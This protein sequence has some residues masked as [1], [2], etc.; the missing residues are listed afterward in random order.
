MSES[1]SKL[2]RNLYRAEQVR[3]LDRLAIEEFNIAGIELM[4]KAGSVAFD[5]V[6]ENWPQTR[7]LQIFTGSGNNAGDGFIVAGLA[8][9][10]GLSVDV[11][12][13]GDVDKLNGEAK[14][15]YDWACG[16]KVSMR[17]YS[18]ID[19]ERENEHAQTAIIDALLGTGLDRN[20]EGEY[21]SAIDYLNSLSAPVVAIDMPSGLS[22][23]TGM[24]LGST[25]N[26]D[27]TITFIAMKLGLLTGEGRDFVGELVCHKLDIP[28]EV[29]T[30]ANAP[31]A[32]AQRIDINY[33]AQQLYP[34]QH[35]SHKGNHG[36]VVIVGGDYGFGGAGILAAEAA[37]RSGA[38]LVSLITR[39]E[40]RQSL[41]ARAPEIMVLTCEENAEAIEEVLR[42]A[43]AI[44]IG[45]GLGRSDWSRGLLQQVMGVQLG[46]K[47]PLVIDA[48][49]LQ[50]L[51]E[52][53]QLLSST[54]REN[55]ILTPHPGEA[56]VLLNK[57]TAE[58]Q[59]DRV[60]SVSELAQR[61]GGC[62]LLKG[63]GSL[64]ACTKKGADKKAGPQSIFLCTEGN[65]GMASGGMGDV[66]TGLT[67]SLLAQG[68]DL[69]SAICCAVCVHGEAADLAV[70]FEGQRGLAASDLLPYIRQLVNPS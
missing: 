69:E 20:V 5:C 2:P 65:A 36:H 1:L 62:C 9:Q 33:A 68:L 66:L 17:K 30:H 60:A 46:D 29:T 16:L 24:S 49:A 64:I 63:S 21:K 56:G 51:A 67:T 25:V 53:S 55:W 44:A 52:R 34:R 43:S 35:S 47:T 31:Q 4:R 61:W 19:L 8:R 70:D 18:E 28:E 27:L 40:H 45:P 22:A 7:H 39:P 15:A 13:V 48:D 37:Q 41:L 14:D 3:Q 57:T 11:V 54:R 50:L 32:V 23:D 6:M 38:G 12:C 10:Q 42:K 59:S 58:I 26:A